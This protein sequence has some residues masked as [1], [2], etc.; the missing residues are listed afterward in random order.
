M[1]EKEGTTCS[2]PFNTTPVSVI[3]SPN[4]RLNMEKK[5]IKGK[6]K[7][8][9]ANNRRRKERKEGRKGKKGRREKERKERTK[10]KKNWSI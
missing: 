5:K 4:A 7:R 2:W 8:E 1:Q 10:K 6:K 3:E 9:E